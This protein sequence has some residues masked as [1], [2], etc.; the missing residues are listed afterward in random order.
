MSQPRAS[1]SF[2]T[3]SIATRF[4]TGSAPGNPRQTGQVCVFSAAPKPTGHRQNIFVRVLS[5]T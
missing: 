2:I 4:G 1:P 3:H 5:W